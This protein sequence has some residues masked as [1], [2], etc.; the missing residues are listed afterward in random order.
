MLVLVERRKTDGEVRHRS[1]VANESQVE[2][3]GESGHGSPLGEGEAVAG[4]AVAVGY[5]E[6]RDEGE[7]LEKHSHYIHTK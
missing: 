4:D 1:S 6:E 7:G 2:D 3:G 5:E